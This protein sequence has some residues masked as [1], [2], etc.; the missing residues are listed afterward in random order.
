M[1]TV[2]RLRKIFQSLVRE[3]KSHKLHVAAKIKKR[4]RE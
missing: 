2:A 1:G 4:E 3:L